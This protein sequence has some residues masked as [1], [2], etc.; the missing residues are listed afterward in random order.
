METVIEEARGRHMKVALA[1]AKG[2]YL[3][4]CSSRVCE[5]AIRICKLICNLDYAP[6]AQALPRCMRIAVPCPMVKTYPVDIS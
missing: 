5:L 6:L 1:S 2:M 3:L 4:C